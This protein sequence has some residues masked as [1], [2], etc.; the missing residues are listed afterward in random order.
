MNYIDFTYLAVSITKIFC[1][2]LL[3]QSINQFHSDIDAPVKFGQKATL[4][5]NEDGMVSENAQLKDEI[6]YLVKT[7]KNYEDRFVEMENE[8]QVS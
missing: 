2:Q 8:M 4:N 3:L 5:N 1:Q 7:C 6:A